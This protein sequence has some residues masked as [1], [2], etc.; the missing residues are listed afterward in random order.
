MLAFMRR[1]GFTIHHV[2]GEVDVV[3]AVMRIE[4]AKIV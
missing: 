1:L 3:E 2:P 4:A